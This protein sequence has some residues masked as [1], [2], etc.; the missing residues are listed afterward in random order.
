LNAGWLP[1]AS[2]RAL[3]AILG[4]AESTC[5]YRVTTF[6]GARVAARY[7]FAPPNPR[8]KL[9]CAAKFGYRGVRRPGEAHLIVLP[10][11]RTLSAARGMPPEFACLARLPELDEDSLRLRGE[12]SFLW[13]ARLMRWLEVFRPKLPYGQVVRL[14]RGAAPAARE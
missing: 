6:A 10:A 7:E 13:K 11:G 5:Y 14:E 8:L 3:T 2:S 1:R 4:R 9:T 12:W